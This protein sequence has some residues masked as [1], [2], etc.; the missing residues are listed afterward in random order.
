MSVA[1]LIAAAGSGQ[2]MGQRLEK[3]FLPL[4]G[5]P[6]LAHTLAQFEATPSVERVIVIVPR[7]REDY[8]WRA[9]IE[10][11]G[12]RKVCRV[13]AGAATR[14]G[15]VMAGFRCLEETVEI[16]V[17]HD[18]A[19]PFVTPALIRAAIE[20]AAQQGSAAVAIPESDTLK[21]VSPAGLVLGTLDRQHLWRAQTP[22]AFRRDILQAAFDH[23]VRHRLEA[24][25]EA[26]LVEALS[27]PVHI[28]PG[29]IWN[30]KITCPE[31]L[32]LAERLLAHN[33]SYASPTTSSQER[34]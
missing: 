25:D 22:Q 32:Q 29:S 28:V 16:V 23:A 34:P 12:F 33:C 26:S 3:Q 6:L 31:D 8:C 24:T 10:P 27:L 5:K 13:V 21:R 4:A 15:S 11:E 1:A 20:T 18:G 9:V 2:R 19:R 14:Q 17:V 30:F 7:G